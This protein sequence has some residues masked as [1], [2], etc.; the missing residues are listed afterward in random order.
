MSLI[1]N[2]LL[3]CKLFSQ[4][5]TKELL[6]YLRKR[7]PGVAVICCCG[8]IKFDCLQLF[9]ANIFPVKDYTSAPIPSWLRDRIVF[10]GMAGTLIEDIPQFCLLVFTYRELHGDMDNFGL[11]TFVLTGASIVYSFVNRAIARMTM[12]EERSLSSPHVIEGLVS[13]AQ[14]DSANADDV[15]QKRHEDMQPERSRAITRAA[16]REPH[17]DVDSPTRRGTA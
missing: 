11:L 10:W 17:S 14:E 6:N 8:F 13:S 2:M 12:N 15:D 5:D 1:I 16:A 4:F 9:Y 7:R 3:V